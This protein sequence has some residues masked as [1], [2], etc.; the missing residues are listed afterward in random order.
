MAIEKSDGVSCPIFFTPYVTPAALLSG[1]TLLLFLYGEQLLQHVSMVFA[2]G[3]PRRHFAGA[4]H[5]L[6]A[7]ADCC[8]EVI[9]F[10]NL[11][12]NIS[13]SQFHNLHFFDVCNRHIVLQPLPNRGHVVFRCY[14]CSAF[15]DRCET[16]TLVVYVNLC[17]NYVMYRE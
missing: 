12:R 14:D 9:Y 16:G 2:Y 15:V 8:G 3:M 13:N 5:T 11:A 1:R 7:L 4:V 17:I 10:D 6:A